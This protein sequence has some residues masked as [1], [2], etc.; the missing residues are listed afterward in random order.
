[1]I[2]NSIL[3]SKEYSKVKISIKKQGPYALIEVL[4]TGYGIP[5]IQ[6]SQVFSKFFRAE[7]IKGK[8]IAGSG[9]G[10]YITK[11][12]IDYLGGEIWFESEEGKGTSFYVKIPSK[13]KEE[14]RRGR[15]RKVAET[16]KI[17]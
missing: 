9:L 7:N 1:M 13:I 12:V 2:S 16:Y 10:L 6:Q 3:Y 17:V 15:N 8:E 4:D 5:K 14:R 11:A